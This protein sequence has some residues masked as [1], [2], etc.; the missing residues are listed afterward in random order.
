MKRELLALTAAL[1]LC[2]FLTAEGEDVCEGDHWGTPACE[3]NRTPYGS[4]YFSCYT[5]AYYSRHTCCK[6]TTHNQSCAFPPPTVQKWFVYIGSY[7]GDCNSNDNGQ[8]CD[9]MQPVGPPE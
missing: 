5:Y 7:P 9:D 8:W 3:G 2:T 1:A 4:D 6:Y